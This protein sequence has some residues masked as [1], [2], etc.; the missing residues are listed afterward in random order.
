MPSDYFKTVPDAQGRFGEY[1]G[2]YLPPQLVEQ[3]KDITHAYL[4]I[5]KSHRFISELRSIRKHFQGRPTPVY[6]AERLSNTL[7][8]ARIYLKR[9]DLN[10][11]GAHKLN[12]CMGEG[13]LAKFMGKRKLI[14]ETGAGQHGVALATA[15]AYFGLECEIHMGEVDIAKEH[16]NVVRM[17]LL[18]A[19]VVPVTAGLR[20][21]K[22]A[23]DSAFTAYLA[24]PETSLY[25][26]GSVVG[27]HPFPML[28]REFQRVVGIEAREQFFEMTGE[29]PDNVV[30]CVGGGSNAIG[31]FSAFLE[32]SSALYGVEPAGRSFKTGDH[33]ATMTYGTPGVI[34]GFKC[35]LLQDKEGQPA[36]VYSIASGL[37]YPGVGPEHCHLKDA[38][39]IT[40]VTIDDRD[41]LEAF[42][43]LSR[44]EGI[45]PALESAHAVAYALKLAQDKKYQ[46]ILVNLSGR[47]DKDIDFVTERYGYTVEE[48]RARWNTSRPG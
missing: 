6:F 18:G 7:G 14:A 46:S 10:H 9:E 31:L 39:R 48:M 24:Q 22:E 35:Y 30:A 40:Y 20:T 11:T 19:T 43:L 12:H 34:H 33:A 23:V 38:G 37:D 44:T 3:F 32:D 2:A 17:K 13:L 29:L 42:Y 5:S 45:I 26:I 16:P 15:A 21:L 47:G 8:G 36:P 28:V 27:P 1:G 25:C 4:T 41:C